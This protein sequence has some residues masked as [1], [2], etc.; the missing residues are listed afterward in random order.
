MTQP[1]STGGS[2]LPE[3]VL[4]PVNYYTNGAYLCAVFNA[5]L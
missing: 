5:F 2:F 3:Y 1:F 4:Q